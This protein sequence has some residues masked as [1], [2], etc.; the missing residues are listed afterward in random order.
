M[1]KASSYIDSLPSRGWAARQAAGQ[2]GRLRLVGL[3]AA[4]PCLA[5]LGVAAWLTPSPNAVGT[6]QQLGLPACEFLARTGWPCPT[7][8]L[9]TSL[10]AMAHG[11]VLTALKAH[12]FGVAAFAAVVLLAAAGVAQ[13]LTGRNVLRL[14]RLG[15]WWAYAAALGVPAG[16]GLKVLIG[17]AD[18]SLPMR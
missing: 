3:L 5:V 11:Q 18:G 16:W 12:P 17:L 10:A 9:T 2:R 13:G 1:Q 4:A 15:P 14:L 7:C 8:G 6:H